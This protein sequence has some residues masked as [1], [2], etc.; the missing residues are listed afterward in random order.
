MAQP[1]LEQLVMKLSLAGGET[2]RDRFGL[3]KGEGPDITAA[4]PVDDS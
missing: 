4:R 2:N 1:D 3:P